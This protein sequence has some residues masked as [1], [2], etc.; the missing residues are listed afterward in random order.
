MT[1]KSLRTLTALSVMLC[2]SS[3]CATVDSPP[4]RAVTTTVVEKLAKTTRSWNGATLPAYPSGQPEISI[5]RITIPA[6]AKLPVHIHPVINAGVL[7]SGQ[8]TVI[9]GDGKTL[10][11][12]AGDA[13]VETVDTLHYGVNQG[14]VP[15]QI[16]VVYAGVID[17]P[18]TVIESQ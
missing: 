2:L 6:G 3:G 7:V 5:L 17:K 8:L 1:L 11:L 14:S 12:S 9:T 18:I 4:A 15:A 16:I 13:I 10:H